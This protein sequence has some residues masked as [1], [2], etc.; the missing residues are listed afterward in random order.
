MD[1]QS[2]VDPMLYRIYQEYTSRWPPDFTTDYV[3]AVGT[4]SNVVKGM[5]LAGTT[6]DIAKIIET[7]HATDPFPTMYMGTGAWAG[8]EIWGVNNAI[9][10]PSLVGQ[11]RNGK[12]SLTK[13]V[14][15]DEF[16]RDNLSIIIEELEAEK[17]R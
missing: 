13:V 5:Q 14:A 1:N 6:T 3:C 11:V 9:F 15:F 16:Y 4:L 10:T 12:S 2:L 17:N 7:M 8:E